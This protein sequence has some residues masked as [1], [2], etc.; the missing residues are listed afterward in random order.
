MKFAFQTIKFSNILIES[1]PV[2]F[3]ITF[4]FIV[5]KDLIV[6][7]ENFFIGEKYWISITIIITGITYI[8]AKYYLFVQKEFFFKVQKISWLLISLLLS[9]VFPICFFLILISTKLNNVIIFN[10]TELSKDEMITNLY[11]YS[12]IILFLIVSKYFL[13]FNATNNYAEQKKALIEVKSNICLILNLNDH[14]IKEYEK[15]VDVVLEDLNN[16]FD[17]LSNSN[18]YKKSKLEISKFVEIQ[19]IIYFITNYLSSNKNGYNL[20]NIKREISNGIEA[21]NPFYVLFTLLR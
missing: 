18:V 11:T 6:L 20:A 3:F 19:N 14:Q 8:V 7:Y 21:K 15:I 9:F 16:K 12:T 4:I 10:V 1:L 13:S 17:W 5:P 2:Y